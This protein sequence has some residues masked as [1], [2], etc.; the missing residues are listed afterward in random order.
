MELLH[1]VGLVKAERQER[2]EVSG[3]H[4]QLLTP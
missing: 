1:I 2:I 4:A 3:S